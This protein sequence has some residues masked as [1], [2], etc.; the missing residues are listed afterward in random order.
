MAAKQCYLTTIST[1]AAMKEVQLIEEEHKVLEDIGKDPK[2]KV[3]EDMIRYKL[4]EPRL[5]HFFLTG[6]NLE[7]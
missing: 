7:E 5:V 3:V 1:K 2:A 4:N 6:A